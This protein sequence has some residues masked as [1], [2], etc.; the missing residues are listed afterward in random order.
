LKDHLQEQENN[1]QPVPYHLLSPL[2]FNQRYLLFYIFLSFLGVGFGHFSTNM[3]TD[4][5]V[6]TIFDEE[7]S[8]WQ[9]HSSVLSCFF[10]KETPIRSSLA[11]DIYPSQV[12]TKLVT[13]RPSQL[14]PVPL[15]LGKFGP[16]ETRHTHTR[17]RCSSFYLAI[18]LKRTVQIVKQEVLVPLNHRWKGGWTTL[19]F[20]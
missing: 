9:L 16:I 20:T 7:I 4:S 8:W 13:R 17:A 2:S 19:F 5:N 15:V 10:T 6:Y 11:K 3:V 18:H 1:F 14:C 12:F